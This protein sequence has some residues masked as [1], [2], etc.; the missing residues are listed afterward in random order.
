MSY[1]KHIHENEVAPAPGATIHPVAPISPTGAP[2]LPAIKTSHR[3]RKVKRSVDSDIFNIYNTTRH[4][5]EYYEQHGNI[6]V[7]DGERPWKED[8]PCKACDRNKHEWLERKRKGV[9]RK[10]RRLRKTLVGA[11]ASPVKELKEET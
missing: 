7:S 4:T 1:K 9:E 2:R 5:V 6:Y 11:Q 10:Q 8:C 3:T